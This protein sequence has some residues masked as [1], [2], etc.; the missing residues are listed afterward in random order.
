MA[1]NIE[2]P[3]FD[4]RGY[5]VNL[6][7]VLTRY[8]NVVAIQSGSLV[9]FD[10]NKRNILWEKT[11]AG[12]SGQPASSGG[13]IYALQSGILKAIDEEDGSEVWAWEAPTL[14]TSNIVVTRTH[15]FVGD[16]SHTYAINIGTQELDWSFESSGHLS[17]GDDGTL[18]IAGSE[19]TA[20]SL[21]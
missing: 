6:A 20:I 17:L 15:I 18:Y 13:I 10:L 7:T 19:L 3:N 2:Y 1:Y 12:F 4:W 9:V 16:S 8:N 5:D 21:Q 11:S 14:L